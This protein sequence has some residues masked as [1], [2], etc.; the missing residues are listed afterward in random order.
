M[1]AIKNKKIAYG[2]LIGIFILNIFLW[3]SVCKFNSN[4]LEIFFFDIGQGDAIY[5]RTPNG[6]DVLVDGGPS[7]KIVTKLGETMPFYDKKI[8]LMVLTHPD[9]DHVAGLIDV[10]KEY[11]VD[12]V[13]YTGLEKDS[14]VFKKWQELVKEKNI[15]TVVASLVPKIIFGKDIF[16]EIYHPF[17]NMSGQSIED[18]N[19]TS[20]VG[21]LVF[22][23]NRIMLTGD[24]DI[25]VEN[26]IM[27]KIGPENLKADVLKVAHHGSKESSDLDFLK[28]VDPDYAIIQAGKNNVY[29]HPHEETLERLDEVGAEI[30]RNDELEDIKCKGDGIKIEC[31]KL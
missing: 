12:Q 22:L 20:I 10:L 23:E 11:E 21:K 16:M 4:N 29:K 19:I 8:E 27:E 25:S 14:A 1:K 5:F 13:L 24:I 3:Q 9:S 17:E 30:L 28:V 6:Q 7:S 2:F 18:A 26:S 31:D 15:S